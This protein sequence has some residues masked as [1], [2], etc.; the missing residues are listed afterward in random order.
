LD[1]DAGRRLFFE[2][3]A[4]LERLAPSS[5]DATRRALAATRD[6]PARPRVVDAGCGRGAQ[7]LVLAE[8][9]PGARLVA[10][11]DHAPFLEDLARTA[12]RG[13]LG[14]RV[15]ACAADMARL[16]LRDASL[17]LVWCEGAIYAIG[18]ERGL[19][20]FRPL[21]RPGGWIAVTE[22]AWLRP[23]PPAEV[24][25]FWKEEY[26]GIGTVEDAL[27]AFAR[28]G[29]P[30]VEHFALEAAAWDAY[31]DPLAR[32]VAALRRDHEGDP[33]ADEVASSLEREIDVYRRFGDW[34]GY[35]FF[36]ARRRA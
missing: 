17:D 33:A 18:L 30:V 16:P 14:D 34:F 1:D 22:V 27:A 4:G 15:A 12:R 35:V 13:G 8:A 36:V 25:A 19:G 11:D 21:L 9:L 20:L 3:F 32:R 31:Y 23:D 26:P 2:V 24:V 7:T 10:V 6:L 29:L 28:S 5:R